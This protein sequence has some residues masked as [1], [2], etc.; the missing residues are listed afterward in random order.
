MSYPHIPRFLAGLE[1]MEEYLEGS[2]EQLPGTPHF[3]LS[4]AGKRK[5][6]DIHRIQDMHGGAGIGFMPDISP[7]PDYAEEAE[8]V[9]YPGVRM[10]LN[11]LEVG[12]F[13]HLDEFRAWVCYMTRDFN[14]FTLHQSAMAIAMSEGIA[15]LPSQTA[16]AM[17]KR[18]L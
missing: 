7:H 6:E 17:P 9:G 15:V 16:A 18:R 14:L 5:F 1:E 3:R 13:S 8:P 2:Y 11:E 4:E 10:Y 12:A